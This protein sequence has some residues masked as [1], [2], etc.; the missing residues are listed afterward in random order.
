MPSRP[1]GPVAVSLVLAMLASA[2][3]GGSAGDVGRDVTGEASATETT[4]APVSSAT[5]DPATTDPAGQEEMALAVFEAE[6]AE[7]DPAELDVKLA[8]AAALDRRVEL[9]IAEWSGLEAELGGPEAMLAAI[10]ARDAAF[11]TVAQLLG[12]SGPQG[13]RR[14]PAQ[15]TAAKGVGMGMFGGVLVAGMGTGAFVENTNDGRVGTDTIPVGPDGK[16]TLAVTQDSVEATME[17]SHQGGG[18]TTDLKTRATIVPCPDADG[19][20]TAEATVDVTSK[21]TGGSSG[22]QGVLEVKVTGQLDDNAKLASTT[23]DYRMQR[24]GLGWGSYVD[25]SLSYAA[26]GAFSQTFN[27][28]NW[29]T[30]TT[31]HFQETSQLAAIFGALIKQFLLD[32]AAKGYESGR[33]VQLDVAASPGPSGLD[34]GSTAAITAKP[35]SKMDGSPA[36]GTVTALLSGG[37]KAVDPS[38]TPLPADAEFTYSAPDETDKTGTVS[39]E[40][41]SKRGVGKAE[42]TLDTKRTAYVASGTGPEISFSGEVR[43][44]TEPFTV[45]AEFIGGSGSFDFVPAPGGE[46]GTVS[47]SGS[48]GGATVAG[49][50]TYTAT[51]NDD[52]SV[53]ITVQERSC[54]DVSKVCRD[55][56]NEITLTPTR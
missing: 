6:F 15:D 52:G 23:S 8:E 18:L 48:G 33:C 47:V 26:D 28:F 45:H 42:I 11:P 21:A 44:F 30:T 14:V 5:T 54:V 46:S 36:G 51:T 22:Q 12:V 2:C 32:A 53:T 7:F 4:E 1:V 39:L 41:R 49:S 16:I 29:F 34:P 13:L 38:S 24:S 50:G 3:G 40:A 35:R 19:Q 27:R 31:E 10:V 9:L 43:S 20:F 17:M 56:V 55:H 37:E 25:V